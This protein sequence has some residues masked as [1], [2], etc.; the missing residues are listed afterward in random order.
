MFLL[1]KC[2]WLLVTCN[3]C[4]KSPLVSCVM[5]KKISFKPRMTPLISQIIYF[6]NVWLEGWSLFCTKKYTV[7]GLSSLGLRTRSVMRSKVLSKQT[8]L[9]GDSLRKKWVVVMWMEDDS[10][11]DFDF[12]QLIFLWQSF[13]D[14]KKLRAPL[15]SDISWSC[16]WKKRGVFA[17]WSQFWHR[18]MV[19]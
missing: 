11:L 7:S 5:L 16:W 10:W 13:G 18:S 9:G 19:G 17:W 4:E 1:F 6:M 2:S 3:L 15:I 8:Y 12:G 14:F